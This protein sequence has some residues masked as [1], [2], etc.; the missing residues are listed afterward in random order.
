MNAKSVS[1]GLLL[2]ASLF[3]ASA[4]LAGEKASVKFYDD[5]KLNGKTI[6]AGKYEVELE[7]TGSQA[8]LSIRQGKETVATVP[9]TVNPTKAAQTATGYATSRQEDGSLSLTSV[10]IAGKKF[11]IQLGQEA[12]SAPG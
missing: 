11:T 5:V 9:A 3:F 8:Q 7:G 12:T 6:T 2:G 10:V 1:K 4:A